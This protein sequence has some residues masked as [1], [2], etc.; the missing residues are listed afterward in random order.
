[1]LI[2]WGQKLSLSH[3][4]STIHST[5]ES[6]SWLD[7]INSSTSSN[8]RLFSCPFHPVIVNQNSG[9]LEIVSVRWRVSYWSFLASLIYLQKNA[10]VLFPWNGMFQT[11]NYLHFALKF[12]TSDFLCVFSCA[13]L[14][15]PF[16]CFSHRDLCQSSSYLWCLGNCLDLLDISL[17][18]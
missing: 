17:Q 12:C 3:S 15:L 14:F 2:S 4:V 13:P 10:Q 8:D 9:P 11:G 5:Y 7:S 16:Y 18:S 6:A 1:M